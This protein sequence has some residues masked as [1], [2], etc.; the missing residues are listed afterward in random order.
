MSKTHSFF[1]FQV[2]NFALN[3]NFKAIISQCSSKYCRNYRADK[4]SKSRKQN[5]SVS[6]PCLMLPV[7]LVDASPTLYIPSPNRHIEP[8]CLLA[9]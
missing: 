8:A 2:Q 4:T 6:S 1:N 9:E 5:N 3:K 7:L